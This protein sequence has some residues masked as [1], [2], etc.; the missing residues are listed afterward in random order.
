[1][2]TLQH[3]AGTVPNGARPNAQG[4][5]QGTYTGNVNFS[6]GTTD[7]VAKPARLPG[8]N[9]SS[10]SNQNENEGKG[11]RQFIPHIGFNSGYLDTKE[12]E[13]MR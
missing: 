5:S 6:R 9:A 13:S 7:L 10:L 11:A 12:L 3:A 4:M 1:M 8:A 2:A